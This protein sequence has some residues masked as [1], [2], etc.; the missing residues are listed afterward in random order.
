MSKKEEF[1]KNLSADQVEEFKAV[2]EEEKQ[3]MR[4]YTIKVVAEELQRYHDDGSVRLQATANYIT[5]KVSP[6]KE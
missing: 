6:P 5:R 2:L 4:D 3:L 1:L